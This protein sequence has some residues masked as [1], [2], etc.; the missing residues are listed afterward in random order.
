MLVTVDVLSFRS[1]R[2]ALSVWHDPEAHLPA[3]NSFGLALLI[4]RGSELHA[5]W[6]VTAAWDAGLRGAIR[7]QDGW[8]LPSLRRVAASSWRTGV[9]GSNPEARRNSM[10]ASGRP[11]SP[12]KYGSMDR[13]RAFPTG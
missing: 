2:V 8:G 3:G 5:P 1:R 11:D 6:S 10:A 12:R 9:S 4:G 7:R 13:A